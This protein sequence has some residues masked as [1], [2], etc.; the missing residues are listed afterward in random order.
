MPGGRG[1]GWDAPPYPARL[2]E[3]DDPPALLHVRGDL[4]RIPLDPAVAIVGTRR[5]STYARLATERLVGDL[6]HAGVT[7][8]SGMAAGVD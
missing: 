5:M 2:R 3:I 7:I 8:V 1:I 4:K 6:A